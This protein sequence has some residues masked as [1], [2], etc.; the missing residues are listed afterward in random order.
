MDSRREG[1]VVAESVLVPAVD[2]LR[3]HDR[4]LV[5]DVA[6]RLLDVGTDRPT[7]GLHTHA[8]PAAVGSTTQAATL[9]QVQIVVPAPSALVQNH[10]LRAAAAQV[11]SQSGPVRALQAG[12]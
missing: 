2:L 8:A 12:P 9:T 10:L 11:V 5:R 1:P 7:Q 4:F 3:P 6:A